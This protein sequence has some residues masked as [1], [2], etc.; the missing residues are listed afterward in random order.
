MPE[1]P[2]NYSNDHPGRTVTKEAVESRVEQPHNDTLNNPLAV[3]GA[4]SSERLGCHILM[5]ERILLLMNAFSTM[6]TQ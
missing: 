1:Q 3:G 2:Y 4:S 5:P 6:T